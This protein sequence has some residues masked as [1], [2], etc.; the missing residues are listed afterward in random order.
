MFSPRGKAG[1]RKSYP[2]GEVLVFPVLPPAGHL[3]PGDH[4]HL[5][6]NCWSLCS[7]LCL[8]FPVPLPKEVS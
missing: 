8:G 1:G 2:G 5:A 4:L 3:Y 6:I 7:A